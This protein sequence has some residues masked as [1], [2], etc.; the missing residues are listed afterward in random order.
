[1]HR[2]IDNERGSPE[3]SLRVIKASEGILSQG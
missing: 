1:M 2:E 3:P